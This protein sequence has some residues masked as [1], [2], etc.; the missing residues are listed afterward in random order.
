MGGYG[1]S[2][3]AVHKKMVQ[4]EVSSMVTMFLLFPTTETGR[5]F[6]LSQAIFSYEQQPVAFLSFPR[7][8]QEV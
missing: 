8:Y 6:I 4:L 5:V 1:I 3:K 7:L 2:L